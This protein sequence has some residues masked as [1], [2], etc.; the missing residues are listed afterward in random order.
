MKR[1]DL[2]NEILEVLSRG[3]NEVGNERSNKDSLARELVS[4][5]EKYMIPKLATVRLD[6]PDGAVPAKL[7]QWE[8]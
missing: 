7:N 1:K 3:M 8:D 5:A 6:T 2:Q 4:I